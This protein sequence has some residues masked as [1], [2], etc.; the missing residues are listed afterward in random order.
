MT[1]WS[2]IFMV[3]GFQYIIEKTSTPHTFILNGNFNSRK[4]CR[5]VGMK[6]TIFGKNKMR[7]EPLKPIDCF[8]NPVDRIAVREAVAYLEKEYEAQ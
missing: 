8:S 2:H 6:S 1:H 4:I 7:F 3:D 5:I